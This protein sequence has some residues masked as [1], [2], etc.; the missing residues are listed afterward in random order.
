MISKEQERHVQIDGFKLYTKILQGEK[1][2]PVI[3]MDAG[4]G[5][6]SK[7]WD[8][9]SKEIAEYGTVVLYDR[10]GL[11]KSE[12]SSN[13]RISSEIAKELR[14][15]LDGLQ[16]KPPYILVGHSYGGIN[17][18]LFSS[19][20]PEETLGII[21]IDSTPENYKEDF[22]PIM[23]FEFQKAYYKQFIYESTYEEFMYSLGEAKRCCK[24]MGNIP[25]V[26]VAAGKK[27]F[28]S[29]EAQVKWL[30]LQKDI[31]K[32][33]TCHKFM[34]APNSGHYIQRDEPKYVIDAVKW[35]IDYIQ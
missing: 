23:P 2:K 6:Y 19:F 20:Y 17:A 3:I 30:Q 11:G 1:A 16:L 27:A 25:L 15:L 8:E 12:E 13:R 7:A 31:L 10:A 14:A 32:L 35:V 33:S 24:S 4:Y 9:I 34:I 22:L 21:L 29:K 18:R 26:V 28:Y 5:D